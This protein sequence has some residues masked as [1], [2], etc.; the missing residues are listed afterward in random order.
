MPR[1]DSLD[2]SEKEESPEQS[3][4]LLANFISREILSGQL[5]AKPAA[6]GPLYMG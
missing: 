6:W 5:K 1:R 4:S 3:L 2:T